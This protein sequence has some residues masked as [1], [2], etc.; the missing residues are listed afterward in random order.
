M[1]T[2]AA[3]QP[4]STTANRLLFFDLVRNVAMLSVI[5]YHAVAAYS[6]M[7]P[8][9]SV[10]DGTSVV[11]DFVRQVFDVFMMPVFF[12]IAGYFVLSS[13]QKRGLSS[14]IT[15]KL[16]RLGI[17]WLL[18]MLTIVPLTIYTLQLKGP[19]SEAVHGFWNY[20]LARY[21]G[22]F[23]KVYT[24]MLPPGQI[25]QMH[26]WYISLLFA[27]FL[28]FGIS[29]QV[30]RKVHRTSRTAVTVEPIAKPATTASIMR[31]LVLFSVLSI[32]VTFVT[33]LIFSDTSWVAIN[34]LLQFQPTKVCIYAL[35]FGLGI[36]AYQRQWFA[37]APF[38]RHPGVW[39]IVSVLLTAGY[40]SLGQAVF[41]HPNDSQM[42]SPAL[43]LTF[44][45]IRSFLCPAILIMLVSFA[46]KYVNR[47]IAIN[48]KLAAN[49]FNIYMVHFFFVAILQDILMIWPNGPA[50]AKVGIVLLITLPAS[51]GISLLINRFP[52]GFAAVLMGLFVLA[53][54]AMR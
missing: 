39:A 24:G 7:A 21:L 37:N 1:T 51:Y 9:W 34:L 25:T 54:I 36:Y 23:G 19:V 40:V 38:F 48:Q 15:D 28:V 14:F 45:A 8:W 46:Y 49:S 10:H 26:F 6:T 17:P 33:M 42:I 5:L 27:F 35:I 41:N 29:Y 32:V 12:F 11:A 2:E 52:R 43:L 13:F 44:A 16:K 3:S 31:A 22:S 4:K 47:P 50:L 20:Y 18:V 53:G 30:I